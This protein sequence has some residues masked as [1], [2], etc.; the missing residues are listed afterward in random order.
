MGRL[1]LTTTIT[2]LSSKGGLLLLLPPWHP[3][4]DPLGQPRMVPRRT[5][6]TVKDAEADDG[7][8]EDDDASAPSG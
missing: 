6:E 4:A 5:R 7:E 1:S 3:E 8:E 2:D